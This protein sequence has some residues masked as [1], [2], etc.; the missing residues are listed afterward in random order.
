MCVYVVSLYM[1]KCVCECVTYRHTAI[2]MMCLSMHVYTCYYLGRSSALVW[3]R[4]RFLNVGSLI[5]SSYRL[6]E[7]THYNSELIVALY[8][9]RCYCTLQ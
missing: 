7:Q 4:E 9:I 1:R 3:G 2:Y 5:R 8:L 6:F